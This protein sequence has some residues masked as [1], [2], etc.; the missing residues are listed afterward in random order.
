MRQA[1]RRDPINVRDAG[2]TAGPITGILRKAYSVVCAVL[3]LQYVLQLY[4]IA[5]A[6]FTI[7][8]AN[9]S[10]HDIY[11]AF[12]Q[13]DKSYL[14]IHA[15]NGDL[16][17]IMTL[18]LLILSFG[19]RL[20]WRTTGL[21]ALLFALMTVQSGIPYPPVPV[22]LSALHGVNALVLIGLTGYLTSRNWA[23]HARALPRKVV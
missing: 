6:I 16:A 15:L 4:L 5:A 2:D 9:D 22:I 8:H 17:W 14:P 23:V 20:S 1:A 7:T 13:A 21:T 19:A 3:M 18:L 10:A 12:K 11:A